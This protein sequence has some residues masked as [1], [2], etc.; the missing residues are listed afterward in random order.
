MRHRDGFCYLSYAVIVCVNWCVQCL[1]ERWCSAVCDVMESERFSWR[2]KS[3]AIYSSYISFIPEALPLPYWSDCEL[4]QL[5]ADL[6]FPQ[7]ELQ[8]HPHTLNKI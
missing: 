3:A 2:R 6:M 8:A 7:T 4:S 1:S 5:N